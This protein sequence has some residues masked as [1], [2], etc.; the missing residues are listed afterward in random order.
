SRIWVL[1][2]WVA[3]GQLA[4]SRSRSRTRGFTHPHPTR[5]VVTEPLGR[6]TFVRRGQSEHQWAILWSIDH[7]AAGCGEHRSWRTRLYWRAVLLYGRP[8]ASAD[9]CRD[10]SWFRRSAL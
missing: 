10:V 7:G 1:R 6:G 3:M 4:P 8:G 5:A 9:L 2:R